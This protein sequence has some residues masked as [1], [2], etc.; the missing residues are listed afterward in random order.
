MRA[1]LEQF[2]R[3]SYMVRLSV[4]REDVLS[5]CTSLLRHVHHLG[6]NLDPGHQL[7]CEAHVTE[8]QSAVGENSS[9]SQI[10]VGAV[11]I[12]PLPC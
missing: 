8:S 4:Y 5:Q 6:R 7:G 11:L 3:P 2:C 1:Y 10:F 12:I 9:I